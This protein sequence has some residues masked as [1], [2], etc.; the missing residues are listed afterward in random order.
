VRDG[1]S[2]RV[3]IQDDDVVFDGDCRWDLCFHLQFIL[4]DLVLDS[5]A[6]VRLG[7][8]APGE[9][10]I[11]VND[12]ALSSRVLDILDPNWDPS[13][14]DLFHSEW[15]DDFGTVICQFGG[16]VWGNDGYKSG[17]GDFTWV[18]GKDSID[19]FP[20]L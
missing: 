20:D 4:A 12:G 10:L 7:R 8:G 2:I 15:M 14:N 13:S 19:F 5:T 9:F 3:D 17:C 1:L 18:G 16:F 11:G 6:F